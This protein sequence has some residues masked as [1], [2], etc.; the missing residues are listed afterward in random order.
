MGDILIDEGLARHWPDSQEWCNLESKAE[1]VADH[2]FKVGDEVQHKTGKIMMI[3][4][5]D[6]QL[7]EVI[8]EWTDHSG[9]PHRSTFSPAALKKY[10][11]RL[12]GVMVI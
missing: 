11:P 1:H 3:Y 12:P 9:T 4:V 8:C 5:G 2:E 10:E 7:G 6:S